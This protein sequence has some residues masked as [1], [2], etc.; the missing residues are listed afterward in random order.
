MTLTSDA[1]LSC[2]TIPQVPT[3]SPITAS[4][5]WSI[6][7]LSAKA[8]FTQSSNKE[9]IL[10]YNI[11]KDRN[12]ST[13]FLQKDCKANI[14]GLMI[15]TTYAKTDL[16]ETHEQLIISHSID[17]SK[18]GSSQIWSN[19]TNDLE[20]CQV[21]KLFVPKDGSSP[22][23]DI[24]VD[25]RQIGVKFDLTA[26][27]AIV[28]VALNAATI[29]TG[30]STA[31]LASFLRACHCNG[32]AFNCTQAALKPNDELTVCIYSISPD[33]LVGEIESMV[34]SDN[35]HGMSV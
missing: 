10:A 3:P 11:S 27:Y 21:V 19:S 24:E 20:A 35:D 1:L 13:S 34:R 7:F 30:N 9:L 12:F 8:N 22:K 33:V 15:N 2:I 29:N 32:V 5:N 28:N 25:S 16:N 4:D 26:D 14:T 6:G 17:K 18:L 31:S 23:M